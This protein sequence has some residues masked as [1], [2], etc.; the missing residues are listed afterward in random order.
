MA[1][2]AM[3][4]TNPCSPDPR[5]LRHAN[6]LVM[7]GHEVTIHAYDRQEQYPMSESREGVRLMRYHLGKSPYGGMIKTALGIRNFN[8]TVSRSLG[9]NQPQVVYCHDAD[10]LATGCFLKK[11]YKIPLVFDMHDLQHTWVRMVSP[12][13]LLRK[14][15]SKMM[16][17][18]M[19]RR[20]KH[21]DLIITS[22]GKLSEKGSYSGFRE[23]LMANGYSS[24]VI[25]NRPEIESLNRKTCTDSWC[26]GYLGRVRELESFEFLLEAVL[27]L[28]PAQRPSL[29]VAGDGVA[30]ESVS[31]LLYSAKREHKLDVKIHGGFDAG[32]FIKMIQEVDVMFALYSPTRGNILQG[33]L[34]VKM[35]DAAACGVPSVINADCLMAELAENE[36]IGRAVEWKN[37]KMLAT[38]LLYL[39]GKNVQLDATSMREKTRF[40]EALNPFLNGLDK[41]RAN[42]NSSN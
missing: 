28:D 7:E 15:L 33:A 36:G 2:I 8:K 31:N 20:L 12:K 13:S 9:T 25:E 41:G 34:P 26:V 30:F 35:F 23:Y 32:E 27:T 10:T 6:W 17:G 40:L 21:V 4:V 16:E 38:E 1:H 37:T 22:S 3:V 39:R 5:V 14:F 18:K 24:T 29:L 19:L 11:K 42:H